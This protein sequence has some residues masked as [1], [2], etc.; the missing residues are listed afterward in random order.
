MKIASVFTFREYL[1]LEV[2]H[3]LVKSR[4]ADQYL[5]SYPRSGNTWMRTMVG[6]LVDPG[7]QGNPDF[8]RQ[9]IPGISISNA[10][11]INSQFSPRII[12]SHTWYRK[13]IRR[14]VYLVRDGRDVLVSLYHY[15]I[16][17]ENKNLS[18][19]DFYSDYI[20]G[21]YGQLWHENVESWLISGRELLGDDLLVISFEELKADTYRVL[22]R[23][24]EFLGLPVG[25]SEVDLALELSD[26][27][28]MRKIE[29]QR[30]GPVENINASFYRGGK[31]GEWKDLFTPE[32]REEFTKI[33]G[34][35]LKIAGYE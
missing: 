19:P 4:P 15:Y 30:R 33:A 2:G 32:I 25:K 11:K 20:N 34:K 9:N 35:A 10:Q 13:D 12:K 28:R 18:F 21:K 24:A 8:T 27:N 17:R 22:T 31:T 29:M 3:R 14:G 16:T 7:E 1:S 5:V 23:T 26:I 6:V